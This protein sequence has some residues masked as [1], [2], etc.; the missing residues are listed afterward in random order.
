MF[1]PDQ[2]RRIIPTHLVQKALDWYEITDTGN[3][4]G[5]SIPCLLEHR[6]VL[7]RDDDIETI[8]RLLLAARNTR[9][10]PGLDDKV[11]TEWNALMISS[12]AEAAAAYAND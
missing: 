8:R 5:K 6:G 2:V 7:E 11:I 9:H 3:F 4:E 1:T 12:L 10:R